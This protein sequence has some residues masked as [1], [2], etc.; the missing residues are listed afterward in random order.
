M[1]IRNNQLKKDNKDKRVCYLDP[2]WWSLEAW[3]WVAMWTLCRWAKMYEHCSNVIWRVRF[4]KICVEGNALKIFSDGSVV[5]HLKQWLLSVSKFF[6]P[7]SS[8]S[9]SCQRI[10][11]GYKLHKFVVDLFEWIK[12][13]FNLC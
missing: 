11:I 4:R 7:F 5:V 3:R 1:V 9:F 8:I 10:Q 12:V 2:T 6:F 13:I